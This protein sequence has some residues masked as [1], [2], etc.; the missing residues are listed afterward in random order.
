MDRYTRALNA[1]RRA[2]DRGDTECADRW[3]DV[4]SK[5]E[6]NSSQAQCASNANR[7]TE[8]VAAREIQEGDE[9]TGGRGVVTRRLND[10]GLLTFDTTTTCFAKSMYSKLERFNRI[11]GQ[12]YGLEFCAT[13]PRDYQP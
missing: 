2:Q 12:P 5:L 10:S 6:S 7:E 3:Q 4:I 9:L 11:E 1:K 13:L 8:W